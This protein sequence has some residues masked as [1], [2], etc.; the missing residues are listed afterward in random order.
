MLSSWKDTN[1][2]SPLYGTKIFNWLSTY[3]GNPPLL[4]LKTSSAF[5]GLLF[6]LM[7][8]IG[9]STGIILGNAAVDLGL[10]DTY[11]VVAHFHFVLSLGAV[12]AIFSGIIFNGEKIVGSKNLLPSSSSTL[13]LYHLDLH[14]LEK[15]SLLNHFSLNENHI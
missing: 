12:I 4:H 8:T 3:L 7:F 15:M 6:L 14:F 11:Y 9:G 13:S 5:F 1:R 2:L 10:H